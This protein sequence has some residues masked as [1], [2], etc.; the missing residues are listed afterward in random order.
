[1]YVQSEDNWESA[2]YDDDNWRLFSDPPNPGSSHFMFTMPLVVAAAFLA[3]HAYRAGHAAPGSDEMPERFPQWVCRGVAEFCVVLIVYFIGHCLGALRI[4]FTEAG[5]FMGNWLVNGGNLDGWNLAVPAQALVQYPFAFF[6]G[7]VVKRSDW[8]GALSSQSAG[9]LC[10]WAFISVTLVCVDTRCSAQL[11]TMPLFRPV[12]SVWPVDLAGPAQ[13]TDRLT[14]PSPDECSSQNCP[15]HNVDDYFVGF[16]L[17][18]DAGCPDGAKTCDAGKVA[19]YDG[20]TFKL[21]TQGPNSHRG[22]N[23]TKDTV[24]ES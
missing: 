14:L 18:T 6:C 5:S 10:V 3:D 17:I 9:A 12:L 24:C 4:H 8:L 1:M 21:T 15:G 16:T 20:S 11:M 22:L 19:S 2:G 13:M 23:T 7:V